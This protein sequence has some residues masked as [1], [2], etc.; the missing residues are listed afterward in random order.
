MKRR[1]LSMRTTKLMTK[2]SVG[3][4]SCAVLFSAAL[5]SQPVSA[6]GVQFGWQEENGVM[7][8]YENGVKQG[9]EGRGKEIYDPASDGWYWLDA[10]QGGAKAVSKD[11]Y[12]ESYSAYPDRPDGTGKWVRYDENGRMV[13]GWQTTDAG[14]YY[15]EEITGSMAKGT[16]DIGGRTYQFN[17]VTGIC[18]SDLPALSENVTIGEAVVFDQGGCKITVKGLDDD[19]YLGSRV[20]FLIENNTGNNITVQV[21]DFSVNGYMADTMMSEDVAPG[22]SSNGNLTI[23]KSSLEECGIDKIVE[24]EFRFHIFDSKTWDTIID[25]DFL[26]IRT[27]CYGFYN[28]RFDDSGEMVYEDENVRIVQKGLDDSSSYETGLI[29]YI[30]NKTSDEIT[31]QARDTSVNGFMI[32]PIFSQEL[33]PGKRA[34]ASMK[35]LHRYLDENGIEEIKDIETSFHICYSNGWGTIKDTEPV[36]INLK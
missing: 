20:Q 36:R 3:A 1:N 35:F 5:F 2:V 8:W 14:T 27:S 29:L 19:Y 23:M 13:K 22:K 10:I 6:E 4:V 30:E 34:V 15:F 9:T 25:T 12:Q 16:V 7:Y 28:Q 21:R 32:S 11:V 26:T 18:E 33:T 24:M 31:V 17:Q